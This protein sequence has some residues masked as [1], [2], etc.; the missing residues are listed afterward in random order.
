MKSPL[1]SF[2]NLGNKVTRGDPV[3]KAQFDYYL[4]WILASAFFYLMI[5]NFYLFFSNNFAWK[6]LAWGMVMATI[7]WFNYHA[8]TAFYNSYTNL[9]RVSQNLNSNKKE[10][11][12]KTE[13]KEFEVESVD[14]MLEGFKDEKQE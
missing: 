4:Y 10:N 9:K 11:N 13:E 5:N 2:F 3:K 12:E 6:F 8:L 1:E 14:E 7:S